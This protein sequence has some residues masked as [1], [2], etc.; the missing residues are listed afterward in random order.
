MLPKLLL[1]ML[2]QPLANKLFG[3]QL[4]KFVIEIKTKKLE[5]PLQK[6]YSIEIF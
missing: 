2:L 5:V 3:G 1:P 4:Q 6:K